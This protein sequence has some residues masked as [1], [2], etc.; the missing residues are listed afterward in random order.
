MSLLRP[1]HCAGPQLG[2]DDKITCLRGRAAPNNVP[3]L[4]L[5]FV[6]HDEDFSS[7]P[8]RSG[9]GRAKA[10]RVTAHI[11]GFHSLYPGIISRVPIIA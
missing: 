4:L 11:G 7:H 10:P 1:D 8:G 6:T 2:E 9:V 5:R 3:V